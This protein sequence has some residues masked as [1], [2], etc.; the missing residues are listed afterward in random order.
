MALHGLAGG[1]LS[2]ADS[3]V[4]AG[5]AETTLANQMA[6]STLE[7]E[8][9]IVGGEPGKKRLKEIKQMLDMK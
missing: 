4:A 7:Y 1:S 2:E 3:T 8:V 9:F 6:A 5:A